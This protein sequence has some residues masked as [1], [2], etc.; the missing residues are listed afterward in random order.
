M[1]AVDRMLMKNTKSIDANP[2]EIVKREPLV[3]KSTNNV[4]ADKLMGLF[5]PVLNKTNNVISEYTN[6]EKAKLEK[7]IF[8]L[9][10]EKKN[11]ESLVNTQEQRANEYVKEYEDLKEKY[12]ALEKDHY[13]LKQEKEALQLSYEQ[14]K[15]IVESFQNEGNSEKI[16][17]ARQNDTFIIEKRLG[18]VIKENESLI[19][20]K[21]ALENVIAKQKKQIDESTQKVFLANT[22]LSSLKKKN[23]ELNDTLDKRDRQIKTLIEE[24][25]RSKNE[26][27]AESF[28]DKSDKLKILEEE[29]KRMGIKIDALQKSLDEKSKLLSET[30]DQLEK[31]VDENKN[32]KK[33]NE[34]LNQNIDN[35][36]KILEQKNKDLDLSE[37]LRQEF[38]KT[39]Q[40]F[41][42]V[43]NLVFSSQDNK[44]I[45]EL[46]KILTNE[47]EPIAEIEGVL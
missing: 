40:N 43:V 20:Q 2:E 44:I 14:E 45:E 37:D 39:K 18:D 21:H 13:R 31:S 38:L 47:P 23:E 10:S 9:K 33:H 15:R 6:D 7:V 35:L 28:L 41:A 29:N 22:Q 42:D 12:Q 11:V 26:G 36:K 3:R 25:N 46:D 34:Q 30:K 8:A 27:T 17:N 4:S 16:E 19:E 1:N 24:I 5:N 32:H